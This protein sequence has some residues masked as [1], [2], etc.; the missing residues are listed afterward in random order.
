MRSTFRL[1]KCSANCCPMFPKLIISLGIMMSLSL[2]AQSQPQP[3]PN[4]GFESWIF[5]GGWYESP[6]Y[7][8]TN[9]NQIMSAFVEKD[10]NAYMGQYA[11]KVNT[12][13]YAKGG[14]KFIQS[15]IGI[16]GMVKT[17]II[18]PDT[19]R[20][21]VRFFLGSAVVDSGIW[22]GTVNSPSWS[23]FFVVRSGPFGMNDSAEVEVSG[24][25]FAGT[26]ISLDELFWF[27]SLS[28]EDSPDGVN[29]SIYPNPAS[30]EM[31]IE[32]AFP[33]KDGIVKIYDV[34][35]RILLQRHQ[36]NSNKVKINIDQLAKGSYLIQLNG[37]G[38]KPIS[39]KF[40]IK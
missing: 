4:G 38:I 17:N 23:S 2:N 5:M 14:F 1:P 29:I 39:S 30:N 27:T 6:E 34:N 16:Y 7:W 20:I 13:G 36:I 25:D 11:M 9:N 32:T 28:I 40:M 18:T 35:G 15:L 31:I 33:L 26:S 22:E 21:K 19:V 10:T 8:Q 12:H 3:L 37:T 24:G